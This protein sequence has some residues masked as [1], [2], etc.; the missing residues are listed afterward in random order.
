MIIWCG[1]EDIDF[2]NGTA[3]TISTSTNSFRSGFARCSLRC[4]SGPTSARSL[5]FSGGS[6]TSG[7]VHCNVFPSSPVS[8]D[9]IVG[10]GLNAVGNGGIFV[11]S[12]T[13]NALKCAIYTWDGT[14]L[15]QLAAEIGT[16]L[17]GTQLF[18]I[19]MHIANLGSSSTVNVYVNNVLVIVYSGSTVISGIAS[20]DCV[21]IYGASI[22]NGYV[23]SEF[24]VGDSDTRS[25]S[26]LTMAPNA[27]GDVNNWTTGTFA[28][29]NPVTINDASVVAVNT[30]GQDFQANLIDI[31]AGSFGNVQAVKAAVRSEITAGSVPTAL[32]IGVKT[33]GSVNVDAGQSLTTGFLTYERLMLTNP[34]TS[35]AWLASEMNP[36]QIDLQSA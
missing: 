34:V 27:A 25:F 23:M 6:I 29:I 12:S 18:S 14:T 21:A 15:T 36:L 9:P 5:S 4:A 30:T 7:W 33:N 20:L 1:G 16:S 32:K 8:N 2:P 24:I 26:L 19:D 3:P 28:N 10:L 22:F 31:P 13:S 17:S 11:G 35:A